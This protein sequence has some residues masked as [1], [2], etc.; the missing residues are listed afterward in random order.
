MQL[1]SIY[2]VMGVSGSGKTT[3]GKL[4]A[5]RLE[6]PFHDADDF[7]PAANIEKMSNGIPLDDADRAG[8]LAD[9]AK[10]ITKWETTG[11]AVLACSA[12]KEAYRQTLQG[13]ARQPLRWVFLDGS[14][15]LLSDRIEHRKGHYMAV[16][17]L[18]SQLETLEK[19]A[20]GLHIELRNDQTPEQVTEQIVHADAAAE[21]KPA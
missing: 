6:L 21:T 4:L 12:L 10:A 15:E 7:H 13:G 16:D 8:W 14:R 5:E 19:P 2:I 17:M 1:S 3:V 11:G 9:M 20:Y 18:D